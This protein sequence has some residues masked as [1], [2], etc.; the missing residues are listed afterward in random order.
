[1]NP[2]LAIVLCGM[3]SAG[4]SREKACAEVEGV[5]LVGRVSR[6]EGIGDLSWAEALASPE[7]EAVA[8]STE[9]TRH[10]E[11]TAAALEAGKHVLCDYPLAFSGEKAS[12]L[13]ALAQR[14]DRV[15]HVEHIGL[16]SE[17]HRR[18]KEEADQAGPLERGEF[19]FQ[20]GWNQKLA[21]VAIGGPHPFLAASRLMQVADLFG[22]FE[23]EKAERETS[24]EGYRLHLHLDFKCG[25]SLGFTEERRIGLPRRRSLIAR[26]RAGNLSMKTGVMGGGLFARD[27]AWFR[28][29]VREGKAC[30]YDERLMIRVLGE[31]GALFK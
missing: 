7:V 22:E 14:E 3:G 28:D 17:E 13:F 4:R 15:L 24:A 29:R 18:L 9:N 25:G 19:L 2:A 21:D 12:E 1:M 27:L 23:I 5:R 6:R 11:L 26:C 10:A 16:L 8:V 31:L 20:G 30:Y